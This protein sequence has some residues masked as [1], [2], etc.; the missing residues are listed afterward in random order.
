MG[1]R[2][3]I[4]KVHVEKDISFCDKCGVDINTTWHCQ[5]CQRIFCKECADKELIKI[6]EYRSICRD[7]NKRYGKKY[8]K[9]IMMEEKI[10]NEC[11]EL[12][13]IAKQRSEEMLEKMRKRASEGVK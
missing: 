1:I 2:T 5:L 8:R 7:C 11:I 10:R 9:N 6:E 3:E 4:K 13:G 12:M